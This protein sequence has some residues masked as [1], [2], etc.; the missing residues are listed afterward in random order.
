MELALEHP[1]EQVLVRL[2]ESVMGVLEKLQVVHP[3]LQ[4]SLLLG[5]EQQ[6]A[7]R[8]RGTVAR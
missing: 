2:V 3:T 7:V 6:L 4:T 5:Q 8:V 1:M